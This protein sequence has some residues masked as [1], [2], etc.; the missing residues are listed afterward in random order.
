[1]RLAPGDAATLDAPA[2]IQPFQPAVNGEGELSVFVFG[3]RPAHAV[4]KVAAP[5]EFR[6]QP[7]YGGRLRAVEAPPEARA[8]ARSALAAAPAPAAYARVDMVRDA[9]GAM[10]LMEVELIEPDLYLAQMDDGGAAFAAAV[11]AGV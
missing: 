1:M 4:A 7:Q 6:I 5:G 8:L 9:Q 10:R 11:L 3:G 2:M